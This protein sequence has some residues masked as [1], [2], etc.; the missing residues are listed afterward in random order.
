MTQLA[1]RPT[2]HEMK[3][4]REIQ[5]KHGLYQNAQ[6]IRKLIEDEHERI[7]SN[8]KSPEDLLSDLLE[9]IGD[10]QEKW[11]LILE[12]LTKR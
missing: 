3:M 6:M 7:S 5:T 12:L 10:S 4:F 11:D 1:I 9:L 8:R 2:N